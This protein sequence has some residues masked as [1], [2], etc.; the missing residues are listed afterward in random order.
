MWILDLIRFNIYLGVRYDSLGGRTAV[1][2]ASTQCNRTQK[3]THTYI[4]IYN[5]S[6]KE[7]F[8]ISL[9]SILHL[10]VGSDILVTTFI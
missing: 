4:Y 2:T 10:S 6:K 3:N 1:R 9:Y 5:F 7:T 8:N